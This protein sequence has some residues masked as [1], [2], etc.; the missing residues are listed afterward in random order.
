[1]V[2]ICRRHLHLPDPGALYAILGAV[3]A[4]RMDGD[5]VWA[6]IIGPPGS[7]KTEL[8][9]GLVRLP[10]VHPAATMT[11]AALLSGTPAKQKADDARGGLL[12]VIGD[13][14]IIL[15]K[16]FGSVLSMNRDARA[17]VLA[18]LREIYDGSWTRHVGTDGGRTLH[19]SGK[20][21]LIAGCTP[22]IDRHH[23]VMGSMGERFALYRLP[24][25]DGEAQATR[26]LGNFGNEHRI[27][28]EISEAVS[29]LFAGIACDTGPRDLT[30][31]ERTRIIDLAGLAVRCRSAI[32]R[33]PYTRDIELIPEPE[34]PG[35]LAGM[36]ARVLAGLEAIGCPP[37]DCWSVLR[38]LALDSMPA[39]RRSVLEHL[40]ATDKTLTTTAIGEA[41]QYPTTTV[42]RALEELAAFGV[43]HRQAGGHGTADTWSPTEWTWQR[44][45][46][47]TVP[48]MSRGVE[49]K[50]GSGRENARDDA[51][52]LLHLHIEDDKTGTVQ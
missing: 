37:A 27:R 2:G 31:A 7:G 51:S 18:A 33:D 15:C 36:L 38:K 50:D 45:P 46:P 30:D 6:L 11:E 25:T 35:R 17:M 21:G 26:A 44:W 1:V 24:E 41:L 14:G 19:W 29:D 42:R 13:H 32:E 49:S 5:P 28:A 12:R 34:A 8:L 40:I 23:A 22:A 9:N 16:D 47:A 4:N 39:V 48:E 52:L 3:A 10:D 43:L 20:V